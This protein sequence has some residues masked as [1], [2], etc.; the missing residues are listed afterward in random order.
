[1]NQSELIAKVADAAN[2]SKANAEEIV[3]ALGEIATDALVAGED[4]TLPSLGKLSVAT[5]AAR[6]GRNPATGAPLKIA[7]K[8]APKFSAAK[9]LKDALN[10]TPVKGK[11]KK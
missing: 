5:R 1:M 2:V 8:R 10:K 9:A 11:A 4:V 3:K 7:A 6:E